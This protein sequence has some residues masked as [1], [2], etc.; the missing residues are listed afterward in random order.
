MTALPALLLVHGAW[1]GPWAWRHVIEQLPDIDVHTVALPSSGSDPAALGDLHDDA[2]AV[3]A[4]M[5]A[6]DGPVVV[7][8]HSY[9]GIP[10]TQALASADNVRRLVY[11][12]AFQLDV[13]DSLLSSVGGA[14]PS[15]WEVHEGE[16]G[17]GGHIKALRPLEIFYGDVHPDAAQQAITQLGLQSYPAKIQPLTEAAWHTI[18]SSYIICDADAAI[19]PFAQELMAKRAQR[20]QRMNSSH[21]PFLSRPTELVAL[22]REELAI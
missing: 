22:L 6:I 16:N 14:H 20:V 4:A 1:H 3:S 21:S 13:G 9:G 11:L 19:P 8:A 5:A 2:A 12:A 10:V 17:G 7:V 18:P 15:W